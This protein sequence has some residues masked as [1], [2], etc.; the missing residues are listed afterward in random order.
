VSDTIFSDTTTRRGPVYPRNND[1]YQRSAR[2]RSLVF[3]IRARINA[4]IELQR[5]STGDIGV[6][7]HT[8]A[9]KMDSTRLVS[10]SKRDAQQTAVA[11][12]ACYAAVS[13]LVCS[14]HD[15]DPRESLSEKI[16]GDKIDIGI[17]LDY[18]DGLNSLLKEFVELDLDRLK[19]EY[20]SL[21][22]VGSDGPPCPIREDLQT[23]QRAGTRED[24]VRFYNFFNYKLEDKF[25]W[26]PDH[27]SVELEFMHFLCYLEASD[28]ANA[29]SYQLAQADFSARHLV[30]W[31]PGLANSVANTS[32]DSIYYRAIDSIE[33]FLVADY[34]WQSG[35][36]VTEDKTTQAEADD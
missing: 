30:R 7:T 3:L 32:P 12:C 36:I 16:Q 26:A 20:S 6:M 9:E 27:L 8:A 13:E 21:F 34:A 24:L 11:R 2:T 15:L 28:A 18:A 4:Q 25:A 33:K 23:G 22:E 19:H 29:L 17:T 14:P 10:V 5:F 31:V 1:N 35:T